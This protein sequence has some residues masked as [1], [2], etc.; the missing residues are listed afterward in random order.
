MPED[1]KKPVNKLLWLFISSVLIGSLGI[2][3][4][5]YQSNS[6]KKQVANI[7]PTVATSEAKE[8]E[9]ITPSQVL[10]FADVSPQTR[11]ASLETIATDANSSADRNRARYLLAVDL[12]AQNRPQEAL[13][14][15]DGLDGEYSILAPQI[16]FKQ[17]QAYRLSRKDSEAQAVWQKLL[18]NYPQSPVVVEALAV[19][20]K[21]NPE[22]WQQ[23]ITQFPQHSRSVEIVRQKLKTEPNNSKLLVLLADYTSDGKEAVKTCD[24]LVKDFAKQLTGKDWETIATVYWQQREYDKAIKAYAK[25]PA[26]AKN[27]YRYARSSQIRKQT[28]TAKTLYLKLSQQFPQAKENVQGLLNLATLSTGKEAIAY[29]DTVIKN[30][31]N[32]APDALVEKAKR[33]ESLG[34]KES[35]SQTR[36]LLLNSY[37]NSEAAAT[38][39]WQLAQQSANA[40]KLVE[41]WQWA[42]PITVNNMHST[43]APKAAFWIG[44]WATK[45]NR[46]KDAQDSWQYA[47]YNHPQSYYAWRSAVMLGWNVGDFKTL[48][49]LN[50][51]ITLHNSRFLL[52]AGSDTFKELFLL[53]QD[54]DA[55]DLW[56]VETS[57]KETLTVAEQFADGAILLKNK[58]YLRGL[59]QIRSLRDRSD[60]KEREEWNALRQTPQYWYT[61][62]PFPYEE[63]VI[64]YSTSR[65]LNPLLVIGLIRQESGFEAEI[66]SPVG[67]LGLM[68]V[69]PDTGKYVAK[70]IALQNY[71]LTNPE[72]SINIG[73]F[74]LN[75]THEKYSNNTL[76]AVASYNAGPGNVSSW[77]KRF[78]VDDPDEFVEDIPFSETKGYVEAVLGNYWNYLRLYNAEVAALTQQNN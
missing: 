27:L 11:N 21:S 66:A 39:R 13:K 8:T 15:L 61:L 2:G 48:R 32:N 22:Y 25:A 70:K 59:Q 75:Y 71:S 53:G 12:L 9:T 76:F 60:P 54:K 34:S 56:Q 33:L 40:G 7:E 44:K 68:Q 17:A 4:Y 65:Q 51:Q 63:Q 47:V 19:L 38:L 78:P 16:L 31:P 1:T 50:P 20:G 30:F 43:I 35:A 57:Y 74:Y 3:S 42:Q 6:N 58:Q 41:A 26:T 64:K 14:Y 52:P 55:W 28:A 37:K 62:F 69:M 23:A 46:Q 72:D 18:D 67:A 10:T 45:L 5:L 24:R 29:L 49:S 36:Q 73:T 77:M